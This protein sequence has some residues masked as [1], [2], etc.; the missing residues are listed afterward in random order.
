MHSFLCVSAE[1]QPISASFTPVRREGRKKGTSLKSCVF[2]CLFVRDYSRF[3][4][5]KTRRNPL[6]FR[7]DTTK[8]IHKISGLFFCCQFNSRYT[9][10]MWVLILCYHDTIQTLTPRCLGFLCDKH[11]FQNKHI[12]LQNELF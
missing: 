2:V 8:R 5:G 7:T 10:E 11:Y 3:H 9:P 4:W 1:F 6:K 12:D